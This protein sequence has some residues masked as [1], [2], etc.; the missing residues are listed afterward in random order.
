MASRPQH[1]KKP[2]R[3]CRSQD[4]RARY[5]CRT[6]YTKRQPY[7]HSRYGCDVARGPDEGEQN[8]PLS[9]PAVESLRAALGP[10]VAKGLLDG[11]HTHRVPDIRAL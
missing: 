2:P 6:P 1:D 7:L 11:G 10:P 4:D 3:P 5:D 9:S 8:W